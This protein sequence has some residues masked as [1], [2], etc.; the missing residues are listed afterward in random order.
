M[1]DKKFLTKLRDSKTNLVEEQEKYSKELM[2]NKEF[3]KAKKLI[4]KFEKKQGRRPRILIT[5]VGQDGH[6]RGS[7]VIATGFADIG[8]DV[9]LGSL[10]QTP[11]PRRWNSFQK[12]Q[13]LNSLFI[14]M[15]WLNM[16]IDCL[17][18]DKNL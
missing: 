17:V 10:F 7:K 5:K 4:S 6:D 3:K 13:P 15:K 9:D 8:F 18:K 2:E 1:T 14:M 12:T 16:E 11:W